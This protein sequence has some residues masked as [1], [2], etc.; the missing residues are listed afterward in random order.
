MIT[1]LN[2]QKKLRLWA[3]PLVTLKA[4]CYRLPLLRRKCRWRLTK[5][6][7]NST[8]SSVGTSVTWACF[9]DC[10]GIFWRTLDCCPKPCTFIF[11]KMIAVQSSILLIF[12]KWCNWNHILIPQTPFHFYNTTKQNWCVLIWPYNSNKVELLI[13]CDFSSDCVTLPYYLYV[14]NIIFYSFSDINSN[15]TGMEHCAYVV[16]KGLRCSSF[17]SKTF[18]L[19]SLKLLNINWIICPL[20]KQAS[21]Y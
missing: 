3:Q 4:E 12:T 17:I 13:Q 6:S 11:H 5:G 19:V 21:D 18:S 7:D 9:L 15:F 8:S 16:N 2:N 1:G 14:T 10:K 20:S